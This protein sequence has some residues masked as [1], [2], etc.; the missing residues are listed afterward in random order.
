[1]KLYCVDEYLSGDY[2]SSEGNKIYFAVI[3]ESRN[4]EKTIFIT[5]GRHTDESA[6]TEAAYLLAERILKS[7]KMH[8]FLKS[9]SVIILPAVHVDEYMKP[10]K[11]RIPEFHPTGYMWAEYPP[12]Y[13]KQFDGDRNTGH[14]YILQDPDFKPTY[15]DNKYTLYEQWYKDRPVAKESFAVAK[16]FDKIM[17]EMDITA[18]IDL[19]ETRCAEYP[20]IIY[21]TTR[22]RD[23][24]EDVIDRV[25]REMDYNGYNQLI[26]RTDEPEQTF[27]GYATARGVDSYTTESN[28][29]RGWKP[30]SLSERTREQLIMIDEILEHYI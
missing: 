26:M 9:N 20:M 12:E 7:E 10:E 30:V 4:P 22:T 11:E 13:F 19:H 15:D 23:V 25:N 29:K 6:G 21:Y 24:A 5:A 27:S 14:Q 18:A 1:V 2:Y 17:E 3:S 28:G 16:L 8:E